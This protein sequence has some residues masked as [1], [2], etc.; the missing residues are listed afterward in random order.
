MPGA[1]Q[2]SLFSFI[3]L[4]FL[5]NAPCFQVCSKTAWEASCWAEQEGLW[6]GGF[7]GSLGPCSGQQV[8]RW[9]A[10]GKVC[11]LLNFC[12][13]CEIVPGISSERLLRFVAMMVNV[14]ITLKKRAQ[15]YSFCCFLWYEC[16]H[17]FS[18]I[19]WMQSQEER[20]TVG[21]SGSPVVCL[22]G[23]III[24]AKHLWFSH[25]DA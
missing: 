7:S 9:S 10:W 19:H 14:L 2:E 5:E 22:F 15:I 21:P 12:Q 20:H 1:W 16:Y 4:L 11:M 6:G 24:K 25:R 3:L 17:H 8:V 13:D 23:S 18:W